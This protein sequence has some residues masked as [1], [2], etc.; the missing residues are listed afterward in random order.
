MEN[1]V[2]DTETGGFSR[3]EH[4]LLS[5]AMIRCTNHF[6]TIGEPL[7][8]R[9]QSDVYHVT[10]KAM[11]INQLDLREAGSWVK[12]EDA[13]AA[14]V[15]WLGY[16]KE[17]VD[18]SKPT[19]VKPRFRLCG[20]NI[21]FDI[22]FIEKFLGEELYKRL[23]FYKG[24]EVNSGFENIQSTGVIP[25]SN[26]MRLFEMA[27]ALEIEC[28]TSK[29]HD[30]LYDAEITRL[31]A[32]ELHFRTNVL[33]T[34]LAQMLEH[35]NCGPRTLIACFRSKNP[36]KRLKEL[37]L[38]NVDAATSD[39]V[40]EKRRRQKSAADLEEHEDREVKRKSHSKLKN[41]TTGKKKK[42]GK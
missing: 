21:A 28:D 5:F 23:F 14:L 31:V 33:H 15:K 36:T 4:S 6:Q 38:G 13:V 1:I 41:T 32:R 19:T 27:A 7:H 40:K 16:P 17:I 2:L 37:E 12:R 20:N 35:Y 10:A 30:A 3:N 34:A 22:G 24:Y 8:L 18:L 42:K 29:T 9:I 39:S 26:G 11:E 25:P